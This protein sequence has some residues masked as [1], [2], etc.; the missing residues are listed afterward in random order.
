MTSLDEKINFEINGTDLLARELN[1]FTSTKVNQKQITEQIRS[2]AL[3]NNTAGASIYDLGNLIKADSLAEIDHTLKS[4]EEKVNAQRQQEQQSQQQQIQMQEQAAAERQESQQ[5]FTAE[6]NQL[7]RESNER[8]A[9]VRASVNT[10]TQDLNANEQSDYIDTLEYLDK[11]NA[12]QVDQSLARTREV[13]QQINDQEK[14]SLK[15]KELQVRESIANK[16][17]QVAAMNKNKYDKKQS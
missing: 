3:S 2:L 14:N 11:K 5:R 12:K 16:Q 9:E 1:I 13:N 6:Q 8:V 4:I 17:V 7:N 10:A 15:N